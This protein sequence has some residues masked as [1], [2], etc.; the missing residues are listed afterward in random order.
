M[1]DN[2]LDSSLT[3]RCS[4]SQRAVIEQAARNSCLPLTVFARR[5]CVRGSE[6]VVRAPAFEVTGDDGSV[7]LLALTEG[8]LALV[9]TDNPLDTR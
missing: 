8:S 9:P 4:R 3:F 2:P 6:R 1:Q 7:E 5:L